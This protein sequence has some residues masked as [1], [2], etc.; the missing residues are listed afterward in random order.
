MVK[1]KACKNCR[2]FVKGSECP[3]C[4]G[5]DLTTGWKGRVVIENVEKSE[6]AKKMG[7]N[8]NGDYALKT[9]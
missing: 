3:M 4:K 2:V 1:K 8:A 7:L 5:K 6:I 9:R